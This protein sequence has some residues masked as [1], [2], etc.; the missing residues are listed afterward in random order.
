MTKMIN[1]R[2]ANTNL[3]I[4]SR[5]SD[6]GLFAYSRP[7]SE[8]EGNYVAGQVTINEGLGVAENGALYNIS[9]LKGIDANKKLMKQTDGKVWFPTISEGLLLHDAGLLPLGKIMDFGIALFN[10]KNPDKEIAQ[11]LA[12]TARERGYDLPILASFKSLELEVGGKKYG[13]MPIIVSEDGLIKGKNVE[14]TLKRFSYVG[15][16]GV[17]RLYRS[18]LGYWL[19]YWDDPLGDFSGGCRVGRVSAVGSEKN[20]NELVSLQI[21][22]NYDV[23][24]K[25]FEEQIL[26]LNEQ[27]REC[28]ASAE[29]ILKE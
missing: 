17:R 14:D 7:I 2:I 23:Q 24:R 16:S 20:L 15:N 11:A 9:A 10:S 21:A 18:G 29:R 22:Q 28:I 6:S 12:K 4:F 8:D 13:Y 19:A 26:S 25:K 1:Q 3:Y 5:D 27:E